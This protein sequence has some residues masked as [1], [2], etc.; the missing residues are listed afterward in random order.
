MSLLPARI[1]NAATNR[2]V[3]LGNYVTFVEREEFHPL[4]HQ[5]HWRERPT[6]KQID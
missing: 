6:A 2:L 5:L 4:N 3:H 1:P